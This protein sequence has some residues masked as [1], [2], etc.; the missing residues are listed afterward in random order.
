MKGYSVCPICLY[1]ECICEDYV[2]NLPK[3][4]TGIPK[5]MKIFEKELWKC[6]C[7]NDLFTFKDGKIYCKCGKFYK[8][9]DL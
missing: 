7:G 2:Y 1:T 3:S 9:G 4:K 6:S 5:G 8:T